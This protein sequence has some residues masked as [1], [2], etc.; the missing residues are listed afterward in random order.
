MNSQVAEALRKLYLEKRTGVLLG[1][2]EETKRSIMVRAGSL[3]GARSSLMDD[4]LGEVM[5]RRG[6]ISRRQSE[7]AAKHIKSGLKLGEIL[8]KLGYI[9]A[10]DIDEMVR[11]QLVDIVCDLL[12]WPPARMVFTDMESVGCDRRATSCLRSRRHHGGDP[13]F[14]PSRPLFEGVTRP[15]E[16]APA[17]AGSSVPFPGSPTDS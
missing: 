2:G 6:K 5:I 1:E 13:P 3:V 15:R 11:V 7:E 4:R 12:L 10:S 17:C 14:R 16:T 9:E 8:V